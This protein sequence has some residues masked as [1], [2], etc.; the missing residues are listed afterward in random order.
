[1]RPS[2]AEEGETHPSQAEEE[3]TRPSQAEMM[4]VG[5]RVVIPTPITL[6][7]EYIPGPSQTRTNTAGTEPDLLSGHRENFPLFL[8]PL[9]PLT[10]L[11]RLFTSSNLS[12]IHRYTTGDPS[13]LCF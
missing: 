4:V 6:D 11:S 2:Q 7:R 13:A 9:T 5:G 3:E 8:S 10:R 1:M 12:V